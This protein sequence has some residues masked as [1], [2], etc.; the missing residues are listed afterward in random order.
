MVNLVKG[1][2]HLMETMENKNLNKPELMKI[3]YVDRDGKKW[4]PGAGDWKGYQADYKNKVK[5][6][7]KL[8]LLRLFSYLSTVT[9]FISS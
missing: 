1:K 6:K 5:N 2:I 4:K 3:D 8:G 7:F 9:I